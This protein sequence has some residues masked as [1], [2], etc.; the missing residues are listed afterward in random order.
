MWFGILLAVLMLGLA[1]IGVLRRRLREDDD[2]S[3]SIGFSL[4]QLETLRQTGEL[5]EQEYQIARNKF[6]SS[7]RYLQ[8][9][10][11]AKGKRPDGQSQANSSA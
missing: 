7:H 6:L 4:D 1:G 3:G 2:Q 11:A 8:P 5:T 9:P 10:A